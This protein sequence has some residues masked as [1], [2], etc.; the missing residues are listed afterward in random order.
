MN[1]TPTDTRAWADVL[2]DLPLFDGVGKRELRKIVHDADV[3]E[4]SPGET[5][6]A[7]GG[8]PDSFFVVLGGEAMAAWRPA[9]RPLRRGDYFGEIGVLDDAPR[10]A[11]VVA[12]TELQ[13][14]RLPRHTFNRVLERHP[15][16]ARTLLTELGSRVRE[17]EHQAARRTN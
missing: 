17:L 13:V 16:I 15:S 1:A 5:I 3:R 6:V 8:P 7:L 11:A 10:S 4:Y 14:M 2:A 12:T 9:S